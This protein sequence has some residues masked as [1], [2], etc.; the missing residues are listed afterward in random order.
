MK[1]GII[2]LLTSELATQR[3]KACLHDTSWAV[4][5]AVGLAVS[6]SVGLAVEVCWLVG[7]AVRLAVG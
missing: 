3:E 2:R 7:L 5:L 4:G 6:W 1:H